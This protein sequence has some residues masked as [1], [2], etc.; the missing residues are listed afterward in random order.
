MTNIFEYRIKEIAPYMFQK[1]AH[2]FGAVQDKYFHIIYRLILALSGMD[3][4]KQIT[5]MKAVMLCDEWRYVVEG[6][7]EAMYLL[8]D[9]AE[10]DGV[11]LEA[12]SNN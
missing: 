5:R 3:N 1:D 7:T 10:C 2:P 8:V 6:A 11:E 4:L 12:R 9:K